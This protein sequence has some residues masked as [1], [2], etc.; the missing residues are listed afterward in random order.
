MSRIWQ[1][2]QDKLAKHEHVPIPLPLVH[3]SDMM[4]PAHYVRLEILFM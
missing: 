4:D 1:P 2:H 3:L